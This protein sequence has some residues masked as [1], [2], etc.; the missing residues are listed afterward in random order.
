MSDFFPSD[1]V[2]KYQSKVTPVSEERVARVLEDLPKGSWLKRY[3]VHASKQTAA[4]LIYN[5]GVGLAL[6]ATSCPIDYG[7]A[8]GPW[9]LRSNMFVMLVGRSGKDM[10][11]SALTSG[12]NLLDDHAKELKGPEPGSKEGLIESLA[13][14]PRQILFYS[15]YGKFLSST[16][17]G[18]LQPIKE[19]MTDLWDAKAIHK[20]K[21][22]GNTKES[23]ENSNVR[24]DNPRLSI[25]AAVSIP[26]LEKFTLA[27]DWQGGFMGRWFVVYGEQERNYPW[28]KTLKVMD[29]L[30]KEYAKFAATENYGHCLGLSPHAR[31][32][33]DPWFE[34][35][36]R[37]N[38]PSVVSG[39]ES[40]LQ[41]LALKI[42]LI[43][44]WDYGDAR[45]G[46][47][48]HVEDDLLNTA[49]QIA[50][51]HLESVTG[52]SDIISVHEDARLQRTIAMTI[53]QAGNQ[54]AQRDLLR[55][56]KLK[57]RSVNEMLA[58]MEASGLIAMFRNTDGE[59]WRL[60]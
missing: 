60:I 26:Y 40:R 30:G 16:T 52:L 9:T 20:R 34:S 35:L 7:M 46:K 55:Q 49:I 53:A 15:E 29:A 58:T 19:T 21:A 2:S 14:K 33:W 45:K 23:R 17:A 59:F 56:L 28:P 44:G 36:S 47:P 22:K 51:L 48:W 24:V 54:I 6:L 25:C 13:E 39:I 1:W 11:S 42:C 32:I 10:K 50:E 57:Q 31:K 38:V 27:E 18:Y 37:R 8:F 3:C 41:T 5:V 43:L 4:P 12:E